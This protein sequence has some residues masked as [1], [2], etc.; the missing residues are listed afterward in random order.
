MKNIVKACIVGGV[1]VIAGAIITTAGITSSLK[2][3][4]SK[5]E[6]STLFRKS[7]V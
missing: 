1:L 3:K 7:V 6:I 4:G 5:E 2:N